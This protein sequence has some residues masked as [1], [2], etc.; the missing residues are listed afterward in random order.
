MT[1]LPNNKRR[2]YN[3]PLESIT[4]T[5]I[6]EEPWHTPS[7]HHLTAQFPHWMMGNWEYLAITNNTIVYNDQSSFKTYTMKCVQNMKDMETDQEAENKF[8]VYSRTQCGEKSFN[9]VWIKRRSENIL[10]FQMGVESANN[11]TTTICSPNNFAE[12]SWQTLA[13]LDRQSVKS[14]CPVTGNFEGVLPD[15]TGLCAKL[16][17]DNKSEDVMYFEVSDCRDPEG[18]F[19][20]R[21]YRC[22]GQ[23]QEGNFVYTYTKRRDFGTYECFV[24]AIDGKRIMIQEAGENCQRKIDP[25]QYGMELKQIDGPPDG[26]P[27]DSWYH[28]NVIRPNNASEIVP[29][30]PST[31]A[32]IPTP[33]T[34]SSTWRPSTTSPTSISF[35]INYD[36]PSPTE[37][38]Y[39][40]S[41]HPEKN[42]TDASNTLRLSTL[43]VL[44]SI[45]FLNVIV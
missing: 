2:L 16:S 42:P 7:G 40:V 32:S 17:S 15:S 35:T 28:H 37:I 25:L 9:C 36:Q 33:P 6:K 21:D 29:T 8:M 45:L 34:P 39:Q 27:N 19:E 41:G 12:T 26:H 11:Y 13:R 44:L 31:S 3:N 22:L 10:E 23:W 30:K 5:P 20:E 14:P 24:G 4:L 18:V 43:A 38:T 1:K